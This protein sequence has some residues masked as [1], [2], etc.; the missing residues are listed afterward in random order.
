MP[1]LVV[2]SGG[3]TVVLVAVVDWVVGA[4]GSAWAAPFLDL[5]GLVG[6]QAVLLDWLL[7]LLEHTARSAEMLVPA[8]IALIVLKPLLQRLA[9]TA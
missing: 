4:A 3:A 9:P 5:L 7:P 1:A 2:G 6:G 8:L